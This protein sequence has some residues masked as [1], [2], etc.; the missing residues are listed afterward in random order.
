MVSVPAAHAVLYGSTAPDPT[1]SVQVWL[2]N[3]QAFC[4][5]ILINPG[6][7]LT[8]RHCI[9]DNG[10]TA[11]TTEIYL[12]SL[13]RDAGE[14]HSISDIE[15]NPTS[16]VALLKLTNRTDQLDMVL[17]YGI[18][19]PLQGSPAS[20]S[21]WG[22]TSDNQRRPALNL[23]ISYNKV[24][25]VLPTS[26]TM[27]M[28]DTDQSRLTGGDSG[29]A[30]EMFGLA[31]GVH[32]ESTMLYSTEVKTSAIAAWIRQTANVYPGGICTPPDPKKE[33]QGGAM[34]VM[35]IGGEITQGNIISN[36]AWKNSFR[37]W[38][39]KVLNGAKISNNFVGKNMNGDPPAN[40]FEGNTGLTISDIEDLSKCA[41]FNDVPD[42]V[43]VE[44][45]DWD[46]GTSL[47]V[48][49][50][51]SRVDSLVST[52]QHVAPQATV[53]VIGLP[54]PR[55]ADKNVLE[56]R[57]KDFDAA[58]QA[59][60]A[61]RR[62]AGQHIDY[63][64]VSN[65]GE[66]D[67][68]G[69]GEGVSRFTKLNDSG[70]QKMGEGVSYA[71]EKL[72]DA[73][74]INNNP[75]FHSDLCRGGVNPRG[76]PNLRLMPVG[77]SITHGYHSTSDDGY[78]GPLRSALVKDGFA[79]DFVGDVQWG[80]MY[81]NYNEGFSGYR[82]DAIDSFVGAPVGKYQ[83]NM[84]TLMLGTNDMVQNTDLPNAPARMTK[85]LNDI[86]ASDPSVTVL[87]A[88][89]IPS[90][91]PVVQARIPAYNQ[92]L[93][94]VVQDQLN[95]GRHVAL[96]D[97]SFFT[98]ADLAPGDNLHPG[99][100]GYQKLANAWHNA[101]QNA[102]SVGW[103]SD[104]TPCGSIPAGCNDAAI[105]A[106]SE[107]TGT[108][109]N[110]Q[111][112][113]GGTP[114]GGSGGSSGRTNSKLRMADFD[115]DGKAD[116]IGIDDVGAMTVWLN[117]GGGKWAP[118]QKVALGVAPGYQVQLADFDGDGKVDYIVV[119]DDGSVRVLLNRGGDNNGGWDDLQQVVMGNGPA[120]QV[121]FA[122]MDGDG[123]ADYLLVGYNG[124]IDYWQ[125]RGGDNRGGWGPDLK[126]ALGVAPSN[127][128]QLADFD[129]DGR[130][131]YIGVAPDGSVQV[132]LNR[133]GLGDP[134]GD[135]KWLHTVAAGNLGFAGSNV[136]FADVDGDGRA[137]YLG[138]GPG[139][140]LKAWIN[141]GGDG[142]SIT[143]WDDL[144]TI[145]LGVGAPV[146]W[147]QFAKIN[148]DNYADY[149]VVDSKTGAV[150]AYLSHG[151]KPKGTP[152]QWDKVPGI[153][154]GVPEFKAGSTIAFGDV[155]GDGLADYIVSGFDPN[156]VIGTRVANF[157]LNQ[158]IVPG[159]G[160][161]G[162]WKWLNSGQHVNF[163]AS[164]ENFADSAKT[165]FTDLTGDGKADE[166]W[167]H[168]S[169]AASGYISNADFSK[170]P[171]ANGDHTSDWS[172]QP[173]I[174]TGIGPDANHVAFGD[175]DGDHKSDYLTLSSSGTSVTFY[176]NL[177]GG[178]K[179]TWGPPVQI[180]G[181]V[182]CKVPNVTDLITPDNAFL[183]ADVTGDGKADFLCVHPDGSVQ[184]WQYL[185]GTQAAPA[186][187]WNYIGSIA[188]G[189]IIAGLQ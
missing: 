110:A 75:A 148:K 26:D 161:P 144:G 153:A 71:I 16:D 135:W 182:N 180:P 9:T 25:L 70:Y 17:P 31:C 55:T 56:P 162:T 82:I 159:S 172:E 40:H 95:Q 10:S 173:Q 2:S 6:W 102:V 67:T 181:K 46:M 163:S 44:A 108:D 106:G 171:P 22:G 32:S 160:S 169:G 23:Q 12:G 21:G 165:L 138:V 111:Q 83:P 176:R 68:E 168:S 189:Y 80:T 93:P 99:D 87:V 13:T 30:V 79:T 7:V 66:E 187:G 130:A 36:F 179:W 47:D 184:A 63:V 104:P 92:S 156:G 175:F 57:I 152:W 127:Q 115:G 3:R 38:T 157:Y 50:A 88:T 29:A 143:G 60:V 97:M 151:P 53:L 132:W 113:G 90:L 188:N 114:G 69:P 65:I 58:V 167:L 164:L 8:A 178:G 177:S 174:A 128:L 112:T 118:A 43:T 18:G 34:R 73:G 39:S 27:Q 134:A 98:A 101:V 4:S 41:A 62:N 133:V 33:R 129:G 105:T 137:D 74:W 35:A 28:T 109:P 94:G 77:D 54:Y 123:K 142:Q 1:G 24:S 51:P 78:R 141:N 96:V 149:L 124:S 20:V 72:I 120:N 117:Q 116:Y 145:A 131:D 122:D 59:I 84:I 166:V 154:L 121:R 140:S 45:G 100:S 125:N 85:L 48:N 14:L 76:T 91:D 89:L 150:D 155:N 183:L 170:I 11:A 107:P 185:D 139:G 126:I 119:H 146:S 15:E 19:D 61:S 42:V 81:D 136:L 37:D 86:Y 186:N 64:D 49:S 158:D 5:G 52:I 103:V 147:I